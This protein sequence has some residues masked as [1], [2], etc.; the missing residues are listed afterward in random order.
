MVQGF[1]PAE[2]EVGG[3]SPVLARSSASATFTDPADTV[4]PTK[5]PAEETAIDH[6]IAI[7][8]H[9]PM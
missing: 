4:N 6:E 5:A 3:L 7:D 2:C 1:G 9:I 8:S